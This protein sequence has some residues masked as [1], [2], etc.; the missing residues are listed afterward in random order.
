MKPEEI[1]DRLAVLEGQVREFLPAI[2]ERRRSGIEPADWLMAQVR[3]RAEAQRDEVLM[4]VADV[5]TIH[6]IGEITQNLATSVCDHLRAAHLSPNINVV[7]DTEGGEYAEALRIFRAIAWHPATTKR[8][9][10]LKRC[11][12]AGTIVMMACDERIASP[13]TQILIHMVEG[14]PELRERWNVFRH[15]EAARRLRAVDAQM[16]NLIADRSGADLQ[17]LVAEA[18]TESLTSLEWCLR[19]G[20]ITAIEAAA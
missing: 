16:L 13:D 7:L 3:A 10:L 15:V 9:T 20:L 8:A 11:L 5:A 19:Q 17:A 1:L 14:R 2:F 18:A 12:S 6:V 4:S